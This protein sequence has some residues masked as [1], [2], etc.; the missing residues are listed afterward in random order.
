MNEIKEFKLKDFDTEI[1]IFAGEQPQIIKLDEF[2]VPIDYLALD[3]DVE[4]SII[5]AK[6]KHISQLLAKDRTNSPNVSSLAN[7]PEFT[8][9]SIS[10]KITKP[11]D[12]NEKTLSMAIR[13]RL[14]E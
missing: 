5:N 8:V 3:F 1:Q 11:K 4:V 12:V 6:G 2:Q 10:V 13:Y 7:N 14:M 9:L